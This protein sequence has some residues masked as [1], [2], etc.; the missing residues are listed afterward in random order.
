MNQ[1][2]NHPTEKKLKRYFIAGEKSLVSVAMLLFSAIA[3][4]QCPF[5]L[6]NETN[7]SATRSGL[8]FTQFAR[9]ANLAPLS[10]D[11][12]SIYSHVSKN[13]ISLDLNA[14]GKF[15]GV[16][17]L[18][19]TRHR[20][21]FRN[22]A[23]TS[24]VITGGLRS[25]AT[26]IQRFIDTGCLADSA[27]NS[28]WQ[29]TTF[30]ESND[31]I[32]NPERGFYSFLTD[33]LAT[34]TEGDIIWASS[35]NPGAT[36][37]FAVIRLDAY[38]TQAISAAYLA[39]ITTA[40]AKVRSHG[41]KLILRVAY[42]YP[43]SDVSPSD[44]APLANVLEHINQLQPLIASNS[45][46]IYVWQAGFIGPWGEGHSSTNGLDSANNKVIIRDALLSVLPNDRFLLWRYPPDQMLWDPLPGTEL[47][48]GTNNRKARIGMYNDCFMSSD[49]DVGTYSADPAIRMTQRSYV[50]SQAKISPFG[51]ETCNPGQ[52]VP[53]TRLTCADILREGA[54]FSLS[55]LNRGYYLGF[56][57]RWIADNCID[58]VSN[59]IGYRWTLVEA[60]APRVIG[61]GKESQFTV[62]LKNTGWSRLHNPRKLQIQ[63]VPRLTGNVIVTSAIWDPRLL[64]AGTQNTVFFNVPVPL[65]AT[66]GEYD[67]YI[68]SPDASA[69]LKN[70]PGYSIRFANTDDLVNSKAWSMALG[71]YKTGLLVTIN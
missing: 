53:E 36:L 22:E 12:R 7:A 28:Q 9:R 17:A 27:S 35:Q 5:G 34:L 25:G 6:F 49:T 11:E 61:R 59:K 52:T 39:Q 10:I 23:L 20:F 60:F 33:N 30:A 57:N 32:A 8:H 24:G 3:E 14:D 63:L 51:G 21:G 13:L 62:T 47:E 58:E 67:V 69:S 41:L 40:I 4:A 37:A 19:I 65:D 43:D 68:R 1:G 48:F 56:M 38:R 45:D 66:L 29:S 16:D 15:D 46:V 50:S 54:E 71:A 42:S 2:P 64:T 26:D 18:I 44:D 55:Y 70:N 31:I